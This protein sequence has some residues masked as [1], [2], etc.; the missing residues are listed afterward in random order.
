M[1]IEH[2]VVQARLKYGSAKRGRYVKQVTLA[3]VFARLHGRA[4]YHVVP[5]ARRLTAAIWTP[6]LLAWIPGGIAAGF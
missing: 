4:R 6:E 3:A 5:L 1:S 2:D